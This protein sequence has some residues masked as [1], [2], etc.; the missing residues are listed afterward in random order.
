[1]MSYTMLCTSLCSI[2]G[3][4]MRLMSPCTR[5]IGGRPEDRCRSEALFLTTKASSSVRSITILPLERRRF[6]FAGSTHY[7]NNS[8]KPASRK[9]A[10]R[11]RAGSDFV[12]SVQRARR[13][14]H[15]GGGSRRAKSLRREL[16]AGGGAENRPAREGNAGPGMAPDR[17][18]PEQQDARGGR[19][20]PV[21]ADRRAREDRAPPLRAAA[22]VGSA[23]Q[24]VGAGEC[25]GRSVEVRRI[26]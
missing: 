20:L 15:P 3:R 13:R 16:R 1:M 17:A 22:G 12:G 9:S 2:E 10:P 21:G 25:F 26:T 11:R 6:F 23:A 24:C 14:A 5:I 8:R 7:G 18:A 19:A 4:L